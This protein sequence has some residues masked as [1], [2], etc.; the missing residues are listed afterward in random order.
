[1]PAQIRVLRHW[2]QEQ[3]LLE[4]SLQEG[5]NRQIRRVAESL[6]YNVLSLTRTAIGPIQLN[7]LAY[8][9]YRPLTRDE[10]R[11]LTNMLND[12]SFSRGSQ[13]SNSTQHY[14]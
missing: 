14:I 10:T 5:R 6:G 11:Q 13:R 3:T 2:P 12:I 4:V 7:D 8:G 1:M 9:G